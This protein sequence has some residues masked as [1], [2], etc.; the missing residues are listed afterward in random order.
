MEFSIN[1]EGKLKVNRFRTICNVCK[2]FNCFEH[3][4]NRTV[5]QQYTVNDIF[6]IDSLNITET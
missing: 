4:Y 5:V 6:Q 2:T 1:S 3:D